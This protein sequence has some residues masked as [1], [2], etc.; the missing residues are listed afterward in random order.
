[1]KDRDVDRSG[2][3]PATAFRYVL[4]PY[5]R[6]VSDANMIDDVKRVARELGNDRLTIDQYNKHGHFHATTLQ[7]RFGS[8]FKVLDKA[9]LQR[10]RTLG[11]SESE[12]LENLGTVWATFGRQPKYSDLTRETSRFSA[13]TYSNRYGSWRAALEAFVSRVGQEAE[14]TS[15]LV[16]QHPHRNVSSAELIED[17]RRVGRELGTNRVTLAQYSERGRF[18]R[19]TLT[20][21]FGDWFKVLDNA[22]LKKTRNLGIADDELFEN[23]GNV[24]TE[25]GRQPRYVDL[26]GASRFGAS[27][28][29]HRFGSWR[30]ALEAFVAWAN[31]GARPSSITEGVRRKPTARTPR[32]IDVRLRFRVMQ[33][34]HF[35]CKYC[36]RRPEPGNGVVLHVD[37]VV[38]YSKGGETV[39][40][41]LQ[42]LCNVCNYGKSDL[43]PVVAEDT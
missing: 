17:V 18:N 9:G 6:N 12:L 10:T 3:I 19:T 41:N 39:F 5:N 21:R 29:E 27:T 25:L 4:E 38:P 34:D 35:Q 32:Q 30:K 20:R 31:S 42:T 23:L 1:M 2:A 16:V 36:G 24:W 33:R 15:K 40:E 26:K 13:A 28:Y 37:H 11:I 22:G 8:W 7:R 43:L 14:P